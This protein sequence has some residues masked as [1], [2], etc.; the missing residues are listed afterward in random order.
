M[1]QE[2]S[3]ISVANIPRRS[4][5][6]F[7]TIIPDTAKLWP[8]TWHWVDFLEAPYRGICVLLTHFANTLVGLWLL[9]VRLE[10]YHM[11]IPLAETMLETT[12][13]SVS[14][15]KKIKNRFCETWLQ[16]TPSQCSS[17]VSQI[18]LLYNPQTLTNDL[19]YSV[20]QC[21]WSGWTQASHIWHIHCVPK[22]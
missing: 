11:E 20:T 6:I 18:W 1:R 13:L 19:N 21:L 14:M 16:C 2:A 8:W 3:P 4:F 17:I 7:G 12:N 10:T 9:N 5:E 15:F 22:I